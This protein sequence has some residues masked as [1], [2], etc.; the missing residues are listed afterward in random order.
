MYERFEPS[1]RIFVDR[2]EHLE[3]MDKAL[4]RCKEKSVVLHLKGIGGIGKSSL[5]DHWTAT[6]ESTTRVDCE[7]YSEFYDRLNML[8]KGA[9]LQG[10]NLQRFDVL[11]QIRQ[12]FVEG[13]EPV[14]EEGRQWAKEVFM[15]IPFIGTLTSIGSA[16]NAIG[17][18]VTPKLKGK[19]STVG[20]WLQD[21]LGKNHMEKLLE[22]LWKEPHHAEFLYLDALL[23]DVNDRSN[24]DTPLL[25]L[26]DHF[27]YVDNEKAKWRYGGRQ[28]TETELWNVFLCSLSNSIGVMASRKA[29]VGQLK[30]QVEESELLELDAESSSEFLRL[31]KISDSNLQDKIVSVSGGNPFVIGAICDL[32]DAGDISFEE[33]EDLGA[34]TLE[35]V[36]IRTWRRLFNEAHDLTSFIDRAG[37]LPFFSRRVMNIIAP[38]MKAEQWDRLIRL[39]FVRNRGDET[40]VLHDLAEEL[41][42]AEISDRLKLLSQEVATRLEEVSKDKSDLI[43]LGLAISALARASP[44]TAIDK[45]ALEFQVQTATQASAT[46]AQ[47]MEMLEIIR[48]D[49]TEGTLAIE[50]WRGY[51]LFQLGR[52]AE[53]EYILSE[54]LEIA[55][56]LANNQPYVYFLY[57]ARVLYHL[58]LF[59]WTLGRGQEADEAFLE[60]ISIFTDLLEISDQE[61]PSIE[62]AR[63][64]GAWGVR[65]HYG[66][67]LMN[68]NRLMEAEAMLNQAYSVSQEL[69]ESGFWWNRLTAGNVTSST[70]AVIQ[71]SIGKPLDAELTTRKIVEA[72]TF[73]QLDPMFR[74]TILGHLCRALRKTNRPYKAEDA[75]RKAQELWMVPYEKEPSV[76]WASIVECSLPLGKL[77]MQTGRYAD[78]ERIFNEA[79]DIT[80]EYAK[81]DTPFILALVYTHLGVFLGDTGRVSEAQEA[82]ETSLKMLR[83]LAEVSPTQYSSHVADSLNNSAILLR[84]IGKLKDAEEYYEEAL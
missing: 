24:S 73:Q 9:V 50:D 11:W 43:L 40:Y 47:F 29:A 80:K 37:L 72:P 51:C 56:E 15:A 33:I 14:R 35:E 3:W 52:Y 20:K 57:V 68:T 19:F 16:L 64:L 5:L 45:I 60:S 65:W 62:L 82:H 10:V 70:L 21:R 32:V 53:C 17:S 25:F 13:V 27:E 4:T 8:A 55:R 63:T 7:Q 59:Y 49:T 83:S 44:R 30:D 74:A 2:E 6:I 41:V 75:L 48:I 76:E 28:I 58:A 77:M 36:R 18:K 22:V 23:E 69:P 61:I 38:D 34:D 71:I 66:L 26:L 84:K 1:E 39:S 81:E 31:R 54:S 67:F 12:R 78:A 79:L 42:I 46:V